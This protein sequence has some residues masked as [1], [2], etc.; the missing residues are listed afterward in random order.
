MNT[1]DNNLPTN[2]LLKDLKTTEPIYSV[3]SFTNIVNGKKYVGLTCD[4]KRRH[5][6]HKK[7]KSRAVVFCLAVKKYGF[8]NFTFEILK[9]NLTLEEAKI[10]EQE[11]I[12]KLN[13]IVPK[14]YNRTKGG[15]SSV[16]HTKETISKIVEKNKIW[17]LNNGHPN[18]GKKHSEESKQLMREAAL[19][20]TNRPTGI[21]HW[22]YGKRISESTREKIKIKST[23]GNNGFAKKVIDLNTNIV[24]SCINEA[25]L[26]YG[27]SHSVISMI[28]S[29]K[30][31]SSK[32]NFMY[33]TDY[34]KN[35]NSVS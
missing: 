27:I 12:L 20:R 28:C 25:K 6:Q 1:K 7:A 14:G 23:L 34:N 17:R 13:T 8:E 10:F 4:V 21:N 22:N 19:R 31:K 29:G 9:E 33:L 35:N 30:R 5:A 15:D 3:Y 26:V 18:Q 32:Y 11:Q 24:Y 2:N 16:R